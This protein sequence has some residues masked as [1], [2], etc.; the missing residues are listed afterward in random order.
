[1]GKMSELRRPRKRSWTRRKTEHLD[2]ASL[3]KRQLR[4]PRAKVQR[5]ARRQRKTQVA[6]PGIR[7]RVPRT[8]RRLGT[9]TLAKPT[10]VRVRVKIRASKDLTAAVVMVQR[11]EEAKAMNPDHT[12]LRATP[13]LVARA[14]NG[15]FICSYYTTFRIGW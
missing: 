1:M 11:R 2:M 9:Q 12:K 10:K 15:K 7:T 5:L 8:K 13:R 4:V 14:E 3:R 6:R